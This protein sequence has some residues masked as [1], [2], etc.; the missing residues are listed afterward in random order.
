[1]CRA[2]ISSSPFRKGYRPASLAFSISD[3]R[4]SNRIARLPVCLGATLRL[5]PPAMSRPCRSPIR[6]ASGWCRLPRGGARIDPPAP[7]RP[8]GRGLQRWRLGHSRPRI[9]LSWLLKH[10]VC[11]VSHV[12]QVGLYR[13]DVALDIIEGGTLW[14][15]EHLTLWASGHVPENHPHAGRAQ[16]VAKAH[17]E[18]KASG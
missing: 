4:S 15:D 18:L 17:V 6:A 10:P 9:P 5:D 8:L 2:R 16:F 7:N 11:L 3:Q 12:V 1:M 13:V 14:R